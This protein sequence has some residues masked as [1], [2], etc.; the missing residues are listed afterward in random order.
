M[1]FTCRLRFHSRSGIATPSHAV[2]YSNRSSIRDRQS[3]YRHR[4]CWHIST[5]FDYE[6]S[7]YRVPFG[8]RLTDGVLIVTDSN[9]YGWYH[10][11][12]RPSRCSA[13]RWRYGSSTLFVVSVCLSRDFSFSF[14]RGVVGRAVVDVS[15]DSGFM[16]LAA[17]LSVGLAGLAA[18]YTI[19]RVGD[20]VRTFNDCLW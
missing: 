7:S 20:V 17:G 5:R 10:S 1:I 3:W 11:R 16:H 18:G 19:G 9:S 14:I 6:G 15:L 8:M 2:L 13:N 12:V 4:G